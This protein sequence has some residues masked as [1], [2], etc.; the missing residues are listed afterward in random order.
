MHKLVYTVLL[1]LAVYWLGIQ[2]KELPP[3]NDQSVKILNIID[4][5]SLLVQEGSSKIKLRLIGIDAPESFPNDKALLDAKRIRT[6]LKSIV[7]AG[8]RS[9]KH[10]EDLLAGHNKIKIVTDK[11]KH[12]D[13]GR[14]L[15]YVFIGENQFINL[16]MIKDGYARPMAKS[17]NLRY[18]DQFSESA[19]QASREKL[20]LWSEKRRVF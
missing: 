9:K 14:L 8:K 4:G 11:Q 20:G 18:A 1:L 7:A 13:Y 3:L 2:Q 19:R 15:A 5:D 10:L 17:P 6:D 12:D 16:Q